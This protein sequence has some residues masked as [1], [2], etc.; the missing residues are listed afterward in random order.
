MAGAPVGRG[1]PGARLAASGGA[2]LVAFLLAAHASL[3]DGW[4][5]DDAGISLAYAQNLAAGHGLVAQPGATPVEGFSNPLW[6]LLSAVLSPFGTLSEPWGPKLLGLGCASAALWVSARLAGRMGARPVA[7]W[8]PAALFTVLNP[9]FVVWVGSGLEN[10]LYAF[11]VMALTLAA[12]GAVDPGGSRGRAAPVG[13][14][15][16]LVALTRPD[17][18][19]YVLLYPLVSMA[20]GG[21]APGP[22][23][24]RGLAA[25]GLAFGLVVGAWAA[26]RISVF[27]DLLPNTYRVKGGPGFA[28]L[29]GIAVLS[30][31][32][33]EKA[34][35]LVATLFEPVAGNLLGTLVVVGAVTLA[36]RG[37]GRPAHAAVAGAGGLAFLA[38]LLL[39]SDWMAERR[40]ATPFYPLFYLGLAATSRAFCLRRYGPPGERLHLV[41]MAALLA[42]SLPAFRYRAL[43]FAHTPN[44]SVDFVRR[45]YAEPLAR[46][47]RDLGLAEASVLL[48]DVGG[49]LLGSR[50]RVVDLAGLTDRELAMRIHAGDPVR[51]RDYL[52]ETVRPTFMHVLHLWAAALRLEDDPRFERDYLAIHRYPGGGGTG[53]D[54]STGG[55]FVRR[56]AVAGKDAALARI[57][58]EDH[59]LGARLEPLPRGFAWW[60]LGGPA[61]AAG[62][63]GDRPKDAPPRAP[64]A[65]EP[66]G[67]PDRPARAG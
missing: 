44:I 64:G 9:A 21:G 4:M 18:V 19:V 33:V 14:L 67:P 10:G 27:G 37:A 31:P 3:Y 54:G 53:A 38:Y 32:M 46:H 7:L 5:V 63:G 8:L 48:P 43:R 50:L 17:G 34:M 61:F 41:A 66:P 25:Y 40:F 12:V 36:V 6:I 1:D 45:A 15:A 39:P 22:V 58:A 26:V 59:R 30:A 65:S 28:D 56:E 42:V 52:L 2:L 62:L 55:W 29:V 13:A 20:G 16:G 57:R 47:A 23:R 49:M 60:A 51:T 35:G 24:A 11:L